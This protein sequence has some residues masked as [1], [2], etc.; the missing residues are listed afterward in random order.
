MIILGAV[1]VQRPPMLLKERRRQCMRWWKRLPRVN[2]EKEEEMNK[3]LHEEE[4]VSAKDYFAMIVSAMLVFIPV[5]ILVLLFM[6]FLIWILF[7]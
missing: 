2:E 1:A 7:M 5:A 4:K 3:V 6:Y